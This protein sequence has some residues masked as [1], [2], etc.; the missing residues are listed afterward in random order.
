[1]NLDEA[2]EKLSKATKKSKT[3]TPIDLIESSTPPLSGAMFQKLK[4]K[5]AEMKNKPK[6]VDLE[7]EDEERAKELEELKAKEEAAKVAATLKTMNFPCILHLDSLRMHSTTKIARQLI[8]YLWYELQAKKISL[9]ANNLKEEDKRSDVKSEEALF[10]SPHATTTTTR[11]GK[12]EDNEQMD[13]EEDEKINMKVDEEEDEDV[14]LLFKE[15]NNNNSSKGN[16]RGSSSSSRKNDDDDGDA[17]FDEDLPIANLTTTRAKETEIMKTPQPVMKKS[18]EEISGNDGKED[19]STK[20]KDDKKEEDN[21]NEI[22]YAQFG[23]GLVEPGVGRRSTRSQTTPKTYGR[24]KEVTTTA[25]T[26][27]S[28]S[29]RKISNMT[30][31]EMAFQRFHDQW[32]I[33]S[34]QVCIFRFLF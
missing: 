20:N 7:K 2:Y 28:S 24:D 10:S 3:T 13:V 9:P 21:E 31:E 22:L 5:H 32:K 14:E 11:F 19:S 16:N 27:T 25:T 18:E 4:L 26:A 17:E 6:V 23:S 34:C 1:M 29:K 33:V 30:E 8:Y 15:I 12:E